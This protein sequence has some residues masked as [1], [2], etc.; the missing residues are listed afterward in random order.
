MQYQTLKVVW[1][2]GEKKWIVSITRKKRMNKSIWPF[3]LFCIHF[4]IFCLCLCSTKGLRWGIGV[5]FW[6]TSHYKLVIQFI[7][8]WLYISR[9]ISKCEH[10]SKEIVLVPKTFFLCVIQRRISRTYKS[11]HTTFN[12]L[13]PFIPTFFKFGKSNRLFT[14]SNWQQIRNFFLISYICIYYLSYLFILL[15]LFINFHQYF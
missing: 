3:L 14:L 13:E 2:K 11:S 7:L 10:G 8:M 9:D 1:E 6:Q 4:T 15:I 12:K 5:E